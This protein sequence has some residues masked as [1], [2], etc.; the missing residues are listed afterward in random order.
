MLSLEM[1]RRFH[2]GPGVKKLPCN[3]GNKGLVEETKIPPAMEQLS[4]CS[5]TPEPECLN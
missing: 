4:P 1:F 3:A 2:G 5:A